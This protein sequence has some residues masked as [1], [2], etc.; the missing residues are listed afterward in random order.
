[1]HLRRILQR[2]IVP[3]PVFTLRC[4]RCVVVL[5]I[6]EQDEEGWGQATEKEGVGKGKFQV[7]FPL[8]CFH[9]HARTTKHARIH[10]LFWN[11][12]AFGVRS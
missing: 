1:M 3:N 2:P 5:A 8:L 9:T 11:A 12:A 10:I 7:A 4:R 6:K